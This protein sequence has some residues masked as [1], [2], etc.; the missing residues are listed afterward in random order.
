M[1]TTHHVWS[2]IVAEQSCTHV[3]KRCWV[4]NII[5]H[6]QVHH[7]TVQLSWMQKWTQWRGRKGNLWIARRVGGKEFS[8]STK[9]IVLTYTHVHKR[10][11]LLDS[12]L[13]TMLGQKLLTLY[14]NQNYTIN[15][16]LSG[17]H[18]TEETKSASSVQSRIPVVYWHL[19]CMYVRLL[20]SVPHAHSM[21]KWSTLSTSVSIVPQIIPVNG[22][23]ATFVILDS[24]RVLDTAT[25]QLITGK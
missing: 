24:V 11:T 22:Y 3:D 4:D 12:K 13:A 17:P 9:E 7:A 10:Q 2:N 8:L 20:Y 15:M 25:S 18:N 16:C 1:C 21:V 6:P 5:C 23:F 19:R 14:H